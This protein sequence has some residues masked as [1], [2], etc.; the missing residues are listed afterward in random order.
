MTIICSIADLSEGQPKIIEV[1]GMG[2]LIVLLKRG[3][4]QVFKNRCPHANAR[5]NADSDN[6][7]AYDEY[8][9]YCQ[10]HGAQFDPY[11]GQCV[12]GPCRG[13]GLTR[14]SSAVEKGLVVLKDFDQPDIV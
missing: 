1:A 2:S 5:L 6:I 4:T 14:L 11:T 3:Q 7:L 13:Q 8:H 9:I 10:L 12:L